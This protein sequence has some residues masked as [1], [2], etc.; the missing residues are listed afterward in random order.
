M[1]DVAHE[2]TAAED[3]CEALRPTIRDYV[4]VQLYQ[5]V[6]QIL[7]EKIGTTKYELIIMMLDEI[8]SEKKVGDLYQYVHYAPEF[9]KA[10]VQRFGEN[11]IFGKSKYS[12]YAR[13]NVDIIT[14]Y[15]SEGAEAA[16][17]SVLDME[18]SDQYHAWIKK[19]CEN[20][21]DVVPL[22]PDNISVNNSCKINNYK[23]YIDFLSRNI[24]TLKEDICEEFGQVQ[25]RSVTW[26]DENPFQK[27]CKKL[28]GCLELCPFCREPCLNSDPDH[29]NSHKCIQHRPTGICGDRHQNTRLL[30]LDTCGKRITSNLSSN[31]AVYSYECRKSGHCTAT[32]E[33]TFHP[34][35]DYKIYCPKWDIA[36]DPADEA[37][38][39]WKWAIC[40][41]GGQ[42]LNTYSG[43][44]LEIPPLWKKINLRDAK[45][46][47]RKYQL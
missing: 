18:S 16:T 26:K 30:C 46:S 37:S 25:A 2:I 43:A 29:T 40:T 45:K 31:C 14:R 5:R 3:F 7:R 12:E 34:C 44:K 9:A 32:D 21:K 17:N 24:D 38:D 36:P 27:V 1:K 47:L 42:L 39:Y 19:F 15:V 22:N 23:N 10:W 13:E 20:L 6:M 4:H 41:F 11:D 28:W 35:K 8:A 33:D